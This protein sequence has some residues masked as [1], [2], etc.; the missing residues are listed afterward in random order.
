ML[1]ENPQKF[2]NLIFFSNGHFYITK[3]AFNILTLINFGYSENR[4]AQIAVKIN[5]KVSTRISVKDVV[6]QG[7]IWG[8]L[9][10]KSLMDTL[11]QTAMSDPSLQYMYKGDP[12]IPLG[13]MGMVND[14]LAVSN[15]GSKAIRK[16]AV[17]NVFMETNRIL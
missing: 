9:K 11:N 14:T 16:N 10:C 4:N 15:C 5:F 3:R 12:T 17:I 1:F 13:V 2:D 8:R 7:S 6:M